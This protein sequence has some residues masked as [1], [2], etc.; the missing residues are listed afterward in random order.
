MEIKE[1]LKNTLEEKLTSSNVCFYISFVTN[2]SLHDS[3]IIKLFKKKV[4][5]WFCY[6]SKEE[7]H[8]DLPYDIVKRICK[9]QNLKISSELE[10]LNFIDAWIKHNQVKRSKYTLDLLKT[11]KLPLLTVTAL[12]QILKGKSS[13]SKCLKCQSHIKNA[14]SNK[15]NLDP[16]SD[17]CQSR[18]FND[19]SNYMLVPQHKYLKSKIESYILLKFDEKNNSQVVSQIK[20]F[21]EIEAGMYNDENVYYFI[22]KFVYKKVKTNNLGG[23]RD[24]RIFTLVL[25][26]HSI[27]SKEDTQICSFSDFENYRALL[28]A[29]KIYV[30]GDKIEKNFVVDVNSCIKSKISDR[31]LYRKLPSPT[32]VK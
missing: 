17:K 32:L 8:L 5:R 6:I 30:I 29:G 19:E 26:S 27:E 10:V 31:S 9:S 18:Y 23:S 1:V 11:I 3:E 21:Y 2:N 14:I 13:F 28:F 24:K 4:D 12:N 25:K 20:P 15:H 22:T 7:K 16:T